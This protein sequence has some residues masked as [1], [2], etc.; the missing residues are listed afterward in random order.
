MHNRFISFV[1]PVILAVF[2]VGLWALLNPSPTYAD[3]PV[4]LALMNA[5]RPQWDESSVRVCVKAADQQPVAGAVISATLTFYQGQTKELTMG[6]DGCAEIAIAGQLSKTTDVND[7]GV[8]VLKADPSVTLELVVTVK[9]PKP[10]MTG[11]VPGMDI[12]FSMFSVNPEAAKWVKDNATVFVQVAHPALLDFRKYENSGAPLPIGT[13]VKVYGLTGDFKWAKVMVESPGW[14]KNY[15][16]FPA[17]ALSEKWPFP[18]ANADKVDSTGYVLGTPS[19]WT[20]G[21]N[22]EIAAVNATGQS[23]FYVRT[24]FPEIAEGDFVNQRRAYGR[25]LQVNEGVTVNYVTP[26]GAW[27]N[28]QHAKDGDRFFVPTTS[29]STVWSGSVKGQTQIY[30]TVVRGDTLSGLAKHYGVTVQSLVT[31]NGIAN[32][33]L[34][35]TG[36]VLVVP[37]PTAP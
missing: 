16:F 5:T 32:P 13:P 30:H 12:Y 15:V 1:G 24:K 34:I 31:A 2:A 28:I 17:G 23:K 25:E 6:S 35:I 11:W 8:L 7:F 33:N 10:D 3:G 22:P 26:D 29:L 21:S 14:S 36:Q 27:A 9:G 19:N 20:D 37:N 18:P 4:Q